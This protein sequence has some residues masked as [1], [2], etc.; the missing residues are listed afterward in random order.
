[1]LGVDRLPLERLR[2]RKHAEKDLERDE[3]DEEYEEK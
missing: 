2:R 1:V 3:R